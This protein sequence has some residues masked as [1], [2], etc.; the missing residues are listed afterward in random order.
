MEKKDI[1]KIEKQLKIELPDFYKNFM[2][3]YPKE[4]YE[5]WCSIS[6]MEFI[7]SPQDIIKINEDVRKSPHLDIDGEYFVIGVNGCGDYFVIDLNDDESPVYFW[8]HEVEDFDEE[9]EYPTISEF[10]MYNYAFQKQ[11]TGNT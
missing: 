7:D 6:Q 3:A 10:A 1:A 8:N 2:M 5:D 11:V 4:L 9:S